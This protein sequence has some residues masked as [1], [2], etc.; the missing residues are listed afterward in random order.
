MAMLADDYSVK[1]V[2]IDY[3]PRIG[4]SKIRPMRDTFAFFTMM[5]RT[6][7]YFAPLRAF[8]PLSGFLL[9]TAV[10]KLI[11]DIFY[12]PLGRFVISQ[13]VLMLT[14]VAVQIFI[15]GLIADLIVRRARD[16]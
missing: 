13:T 16:R 5:I 10:V 7:L 12:Q 8:M 2:P 4:R 15:L 1:Y 14:L 3:L 11:Y 6:C 9:L